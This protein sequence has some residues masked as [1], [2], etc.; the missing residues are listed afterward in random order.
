[1]Q[2]LFVT[3]TRLGDGVLSTGLLAEVQRR[4]PDAQITVVCGGLPA[5]I[6]RA[7]PGIHEVIVLQKQRYA[8]HWVDLFRRTRQ[9]EWDWIIDLRNVPLLR[10]LSAKKRS[11]AVKRQAQSHKVAELSEVIGA[12][13]LD[14][15]I[16]TNEQARTTA[17]DLLA[18]VGTFLAIS[19]AAGGPAK[20]WSQARFLVLAERLTQPGGPMSLARIVVL[21]TDVDEGRVAGLL[22]TLP[23]KRTI[24]L[25]GRTDPLEA[26]AVLERARLFVGNDSGLAHISAAVGTP[27]LA[28]FGGGFPE[29]YRPWGTNAEYVHSRPSP[30]PEQA[31]NPA[32][33]HTGGQMSALSLADVYEAAYQL[34]ERTRS[35]HSA[36][37]AQQSAS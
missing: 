37:E 27:T 7:F 33:V 36:P 29:I 31:A 17:N 30:T 28:L 13:P 23:P 4:H 25:M 26:A 5:P 34:I 24:N 22:E 15:I 14:P 9:T 21:G 8:T 12:G 2:V 6:F 32:W 18:G 10:F 11:V 19:P 20:E 3:S 35:E 1:M 16:H